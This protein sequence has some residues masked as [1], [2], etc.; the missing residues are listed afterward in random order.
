MSDTSRRSRILFSILVVVAMAFWGGAWSIAKLVTGTISVQTVV[1]YRFFISA[2]AIFPVVFIFRHGFRLD[3]RGFLW[4][5]CG[6]GLFTA[7]NELFFT[8]VKLG[9]AGAGGVLVTTTNPIFTYVLVVILFR[10]RL[11]LWTVF[12][13]ALG[14]FGGCVML[15]L[16]TFEGEEIFRL[17]NG[18]FLIS[19]VVWAGVTV[20]SGHAQKTVH[21]STYTFYFYLFSAVLSLPFSLIT[22]DT[23]LVFGQ[24]PVFW[25]QLLYLGVF[26][27]AFAASVF[28]IASNRLGSHRASHFV[29]LIPAFALLSSFLILGEVPKW[30]TV[31]GGLMAL[32]AVYILNRQRQKTH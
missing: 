5:L 16:W 28:F 31:L 20:V 19:A 32:G 18:I 9:L 10:H 12:G 27:M 15:R 8:G 4:T 30:Y 7:Y 26:A 11:S 22:G 17:G 14:F 1:F 24:G 6:A 3:R 13:L 23:L 21:F 29:F 2:L 25:L